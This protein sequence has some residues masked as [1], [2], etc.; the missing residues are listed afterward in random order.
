[1]SKTFEMQ[2]LYTQLIFGVP[3]IHLMLAYA[4]LIVK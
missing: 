2:N 3:D 4:F 1:M